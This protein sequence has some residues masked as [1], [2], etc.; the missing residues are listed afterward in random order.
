MHSIVSRSGVDKS[1][2]ITE[3]VRLIDELWETTPQDEQEA[4][5]SVLAVVFSMGRLLLGALIAR[6]CWQKAMMEIEERGDAPADVRFRLDR[7]YWSSPKTTLGT[8]HFPRFV[9]R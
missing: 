8:V 1:D 9:F 7:D 6:H 2:V 3:V 4:E 5:S